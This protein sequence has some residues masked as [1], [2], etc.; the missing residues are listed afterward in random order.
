MFSEKGAHGKSMKN[1]LMDSLFEQ[2]N[3]RDEPATINKI[4]VYYDMTMNQMNK[5]DTE[6]K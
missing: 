5:K 6:D 3:E 2:S 1:F 4:H